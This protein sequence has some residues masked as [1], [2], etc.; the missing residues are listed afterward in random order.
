MI[1]DRREKCVRVCDKKKKEFNISGICLIR[2]KLNRSQFPFQGHETS[3][4]REKERKNS[5]GNLSRR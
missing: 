4:N 5:R 3:Y 2:N 1:I